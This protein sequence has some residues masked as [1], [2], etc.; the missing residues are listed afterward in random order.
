M[1]ETHEGPSGVDYQVNS[2]LELTVGDRAHVDRVKIGL[3][4]A[5]ALHVSSLMASIGSQA[6]FSDFAFTTGSALTR[7]QLA[8]RCAGEGSIL[9]LSGASLLNGR[10]HVDNTLVVDH[11]QGGCT[12]REVFKTVLD[13]E[14]RGVFQGKS[15]CGRARRRPT[16]GGFECTAAV[17]DRR[18]RQTAELEV[19]ADD[20]QCG[21]GA[22]TARSMKTSSSISWRAHSEKQAETL[23]IQAF[24]GGAVETIEHAGLREILIE[25]TGHWLA[26]RE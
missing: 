22:T 6:R 19:F 23:L 14:S 13:G 15:S 1:I 16:A 12:S 25:A 9:H 7:N 3:E 10:Q 11:A 26:A 20:V 21:H 17:G 8:A 4:G 18:G 2:A 5:N 24:V